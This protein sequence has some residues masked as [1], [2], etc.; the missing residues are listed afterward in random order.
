MSQSR[1]HAQARGQ[2]LEAGEPA[3]VPAH[4]E[5]ARQEALRP[6]VEGKRVDPAPDGGMDCPTSRDPDPQTLQGRERQ[7]AAV[8]AA[9]A[10]EGPCQADAAPG[11]ARGGRERLVQWL[12]EREPS[13]RLPPADQAASGTEG[14]VTGPWQACGAR[15]GPSGGSVGW[16]PSW[17]SAGGGSAGGS[18]RSPTWRWW[19][20]GRS[21]ATRW[22]TARG[23]SQA[24]R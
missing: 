1:A 2:E 8:S 3:H 19:P 15:R 9:A 23:A 20:L 21:P 18:G 7:V 5:E 16:G 12:P 6:P 4:V 14:A 11:H 13:G 17:G 24:G 22:W 10:P